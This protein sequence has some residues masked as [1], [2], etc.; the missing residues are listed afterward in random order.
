[1][2]N[3][4]LVLNFKDTPVIN[5]CLLLTSCYI[6]CYISRQPGIKNIYNT[7]KNDIQI[8]SLWQ[9]L[10]M[11]VTILDQHGSCVCVVV[12][13][14]VE[15]YQHIHERFKL[16][17]HSL[18]WNNFQSFI[19]F[20]MVDFSAIWFLPSFPGINTTQTDQLQN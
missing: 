17:D 18:R 20:L 1:M 19:N 16:F 14:C 6:Y 3:L 5:N 7:S 2:V 10:L 11:I 15:R 4:N 13:K 8:N 12:C 9:W